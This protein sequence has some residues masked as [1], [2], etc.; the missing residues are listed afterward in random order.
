MD[1]EAQVVTRIQMDDIKRIQ[2]DAKPQ[3]KHGLTS[4]DNP[5]YPHPAGRRHI[6]VRPDSETFSAGQFTTEP[7]DGMTVHLN[8]EREQLYSPHVTIWLHIREPGPDGKP[9]NCHHFIPL[10]DDQA[11][12]LALMLCNAAS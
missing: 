2:M 3:V 1:A 8:V 11:R 7:V 12:T 4:L 5:G 6:R 10:T 9:A